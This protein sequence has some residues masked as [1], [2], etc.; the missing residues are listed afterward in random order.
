MGN[1]LITLLIA[2]GC[3]AAAEE[4]LEVIVMDPLAL[5]LSCTCVKGTGQRRYEALAAHLEKNAGRTVRL[6]FD[7]SL[8]LALPRTQGKADLI[9]GKD[10]VVRTDAL[11]AKLRVR[12]LAALTDTHGSTGVRGTFLVPKDSPVRSLHD[13][14]GKRVSIGPVEDAEAHAAAKRAL[15]GIPDIT[16]QTAGSMDSAALAMDDGESAAA[17]VSS[18]MPVLLEG[19]GKLEKGGTRILAETAPVPFIRVFATEGI[20]DDLEARITA[21]L[22]AVSRSPALLAAL[23]SRDGFVLPSK[24]ATGRDWPDWRGPGR[25]GQVP[26]L[27]AKIPADFT[28][29]WTR[30]LTGPAM[31]GAAVSGGRLVIPDKSAD[32]RRDI[33]LCLDMRD[34]RELWR[35]EYEAAGDIEYSNAPRATPVIHDGLVYVQGAHGHLHCMELSTG[36]VVW[37]ANIFTDFAAERLHWGASAAPLIVEDK[38]IIAP[39]AKDASVAALDRKTGALKWKT[40]GNAAAYSAFILATFDGVTQII[41]YDSGSLGGWHL[42]SGERLW[43]LVPHDGSDFNVTTPVVVGDKLLLATENNGT[44]LHR[45]D[46]KGRIVA[47]PLARND[48]L[49]PDTCTP[50]VAGRRVLATAYGELFCLDLDRGLQTVWRQAGDEFHDH[51]NVITSADHALLWTSDGDLILLGAQSDTFAPI[52]RLRPFDEKHPDTLAHP[53][54]AAGRLYLRSSKTLACFVLPE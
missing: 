41:G 47:K 4:P 6:T 34:G 22:L 43:T 36:R 9:I 7:E 53:A 42:E 52:A 10:P 13:L 8:A 1:R 15:Q 2:L 5:Q 3:V 54:I 30:S 12:L 16:L 38:L 49:A 40:P 17:V 51:C 37:K 21:A 24:D 50:G 28:P 48:D 27:P 32:A 35:L 44:R 20:S 31:A 29:L 33:F 46:G 26:A 19:C 23:E 11:K 25:S 39:G 14:R 45:F 18:F